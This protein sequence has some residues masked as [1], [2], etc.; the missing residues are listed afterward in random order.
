MRAEDEAW[1]LQGPFCPLTQLRNRNLRRRL[2]PPTRNL[3]V[4][5]EDLSKLL[6]LGSKAEVLTLLSDRLQGLDEVE[7]V[8]AKAAAGLLRHGRGCRVA[9]AWQGLHW[10]PGTLGLSQPHLC[11]GVG[12]L[13]VPRQSNTRLSA[14]SCPGP[15]GRA[16]AVL[17][18]C[19]SGIRDRVVQFFK[20][21]V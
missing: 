2:P 7:V 21:S 19:T 9:R 11:Q 1:P 16:T 17:C 14:W 18:Y 3:R 12:C 20:W 10:N 5:C 4:H 8:F 13:S 6:P 15:L